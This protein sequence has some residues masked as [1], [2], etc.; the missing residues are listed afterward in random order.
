METFFDKSDSVLKTVVYGS[1]FCRYLVSRCSSRENDVERIER[2]T[3][4]FYRIRS[5]IGIVGIY[6]DWRSLPQ[7]W[8]T[9]A[10]KEGVRWKEVCNTAVLCSGIASN[11]MDFFAALMWLIPR[12]YNLYLRMRA[13]LNVV[14]W[15][16]PKR[17]PHSS[18]SVPPMDVTSDV[19]SQEASSDRLDDVRERV[20]WLSNVFW[21]SMSTLSLISSLY[22]LY[23]A[24]RKAKSQTIR[25]PEE[26]EEEEEEEPTV[27]EAG[28][29]ALECALDLVGGAS[30]AF[31]LDIEAE[32]A[33]AIGPT[34]ASCVHFAQLALQNSESDEGEVEKAQSEVQMDEK[35][36]GKRIEAISVPL[37]PE[38]LGNLEV[39]DPE[40][41]V[42]DDKPE[43]EPSPR[44]RKFSELENKKGDSSPLTDNSSLWNKEF[45]EKIRDE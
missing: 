45:Q 35:L 13:W 36:T 40:P 30:G 31:K 14:S 42:E 16:R 17:R 26:E 33:T 2:V 29:E 1:A 15:L 28:L 6:L 24:L 9:L 3:D 4:I 20:E 39:V 5:V 10:K 11:A 37:A 43:G 8:A 38:N 25:T 23:S 7:S 44:E 19:A 12:V 22:A 21:A 34:L 41:I 27:K 18:L 32:G